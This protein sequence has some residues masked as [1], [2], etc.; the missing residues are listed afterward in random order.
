MKGQKPYNKGIKMNKKQ[1]E[2][3]EKKVYNKR[4]G[5]NYEE[6]YGKEKAKEI[7]KKQLNSFTPKRR[8]EMSLIKK[9]KKHSEDTKKKI[10]LG[11]TG[12]EVSKETREKIRNKLMGHK[13]SKETR[14]KMQEKT[15]GRK[16][17]TEIRKRKSERMKKEYSSGLRISAMKGKTHSKEARAKISFGMK[18]DKHWNWLGGKSFEP[19]TKEFNKEFKRKIKVRDGRMCLKCGMKEEDHMRVWGL[20][21]SIHHINYNKKLTILQNCCTLCNRCNTEVNYNRNQW[22]EFFRSM[23]SERYYY[24]YKKEIKNGMD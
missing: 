11:N 22:I 16:E 8:L 5:K 3:M 9:G 4:K 24:R 10:S 19:Y 23:L 1:R 6:I 2:I 21:L 20:G 12:K 18:L 15:K 7:V 13:V 14:K 17:S